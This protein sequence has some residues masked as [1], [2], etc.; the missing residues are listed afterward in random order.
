MKSRSQRGT[1]SG[2]FVAIIPARGGSKGIPRKNLADLGGKPLLAHSI[3]VALACGRFARVVVSTEDAAIARTALEYGAEIP[4][5]RPRRLAT[6]CASPGDVFNHMMG[7]LNRGRRRPYVGYVALYP[8]H[9]FRSLAVMH[10]LMDALEA[11]RRRV[12]SVRA[13]RPGEIGYYSMDDACALT[14]LPFPDS[15]QVTGCVRPYG[16]FDGM[17]F[18]PRAQGLYAHAITDPVQLVDI[19]EPQDLELARLVVTQGL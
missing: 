6:D 5:V 4:V 16:L 10:R 7:V 14:R 11:G 12:V 8:T 17:S 18:A 9:P 2:R 1:V 3:E 13:M 15:A 19:D